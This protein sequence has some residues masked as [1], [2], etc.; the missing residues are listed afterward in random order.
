V[1]CNLKGMK[2][3]MYK[4]YWS[5]QKVFG[6]IVSMKGCC[7]FCY[8]DNIEYGACLR[9]GLLKKKFDLNKLFGMFQTLYATVSMEVSIDGERT[10]FHFFL[11]QKL[12]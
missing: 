5:L 9:K 6:H 11:Y 2:G 12:K 3:V 7:I 10:R 1:V 4:F 8:F